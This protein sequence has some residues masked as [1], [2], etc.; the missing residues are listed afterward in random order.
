MTPYESWIGLKLDL[1]KLKVWGCKSHVLIPRPLRNKLKDKTWECKFIGYSE[2]G[3][4]Y[5]FYH[6]E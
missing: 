5:R 6:P 3:N 4:G 1:T 2:S